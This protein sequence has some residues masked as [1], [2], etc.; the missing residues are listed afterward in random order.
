MTI[1]TL[2][3]RLIEAGFSCG[4][5]GA[6]GVFGAKTLTAA[7]GYVARRQPDKAISDRAALIL[8]YWKP[9]SD[10]NPQGWSYLRLIH[11][12]AQV[13]HET[14]GWTKFEENLHYTTP[15]RLMA[16]FPSTVKTLAQAAA[17]IKAGPQAIAN[18]VYAGKNGNGDEASGDGWRCRGQGD[19]Q[20]TGLKNYKLYG[21]AIGLNLVDHPDIVQQPD[22]SVRVALA[23]WRLN[24]CNAWADQG[25]TARIT[26]L[27]N[28]KGME[29]LQAR[30]DKVAR[31]RDVWGV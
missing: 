18:H 24:S 12:L 14:A 2:Q 21:D 17:L 7:M 30:K 29:G 6:D 3:T 1:K 13:C 26:L 25:N 4:P 16:V 23:Y 15:E 9:Q 20:I 5:A 22:V 8:Q 19:I 28:G 11:F 27:I 31:L 10:Q